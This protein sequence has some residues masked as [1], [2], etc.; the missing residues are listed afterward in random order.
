[1]GGDGGGA[2]ELGVG[3]HSAHGVGHA[4]AGGAGGHVVGVKRSAGAAA[5]SNGEVFNAVFYAPFFIG[6][7]DGV[8]E[9]CRVGRVAGDRNADVLKLHYGHALGDVVGAVA[10]NVGARAVRVGLFVDDLN[11]LGEGIELGL[12][13]GEAVDPRDDE[14]GVLAEAVQDNAERLGSYL[15][16]V[17]GDLYGAFGGGK[18]LVAGK[19]AE[20]FGGF[21]QKHGSEISVAEADLSVFGDRAGYAEALKSLADGDGGVCGL[22]AALLYGDSA[23]YGVGPNGVFKADGLG[24]ADYLIA[25]DPLSKGDLFAFLNRGDTV[26][27]KNRVYFVDSSLIVFK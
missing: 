14:G 10:L 8:L 12:N 7:G 22:L 20:A 11:L 13:I 21:G 4:V 17:E 9:S 25:V 24:L 2:G 19:E 18:A 23:A 5:G 26:L 15:V 27:S 16:G 6:A 1:M 3:V